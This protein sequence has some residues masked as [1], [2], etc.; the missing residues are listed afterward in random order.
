MLL[1]HCMDE[2]I[3]ALQMDGREKRRTEWGEGERERPSSPGESQ[4]PLGGL[5]PAFFLLSSTLEESI[6]QAIILFVL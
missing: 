2:V 6:A 1:A 5:D 4:G 3:E